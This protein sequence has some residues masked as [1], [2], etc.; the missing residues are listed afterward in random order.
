[1]LSAESHRILGVSPEPLEDPRAALRDSL[2]ESSPGSVPEPSALA[3][4]QPTP[5]SHPDS[6]EGLPI[7]RSLPAGR[8]QWAACTA[9]CGCLPGG[10]EWFPIRQPKSEAI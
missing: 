4:V 8:S 2:L 6:G 9:E 1:M 10:W 7:S 5:A 3:A